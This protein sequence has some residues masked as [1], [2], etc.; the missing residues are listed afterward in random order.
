[1]VIAILAIALSMASYIFAGEFITASL[2][3]FVLFSRKRVF[4]VKHSHYY[5]L[6]A[7]VLQLVLTVGL[8]LILA[9]TDFAVQ[10]GNRSYFDC[11]YFAMMTLTT[12]GFGDMWWSSEQ[13]Y[14]CLLYTSPS[15]R[16]S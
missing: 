7:V 13:Y 8:W 4:G 10:K 2:H 5:E 11:T 14:D 16:D 6:H 9:A 15:P 12:V 3:L 1:M